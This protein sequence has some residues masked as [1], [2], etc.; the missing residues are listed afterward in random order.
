MSQST[1]AALA[2]TIPEACRLSGLGRSTIY[3]L[4][5]SGRLKSSTIGKRRLILLASLREVIE[6]GAKLAERSGKT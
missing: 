6:T 2:A 1:E 5:K 4:V 3:E